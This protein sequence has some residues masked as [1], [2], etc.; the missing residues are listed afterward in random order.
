MGDRVMKIKRFKRIEDSGKFIDY[1]QWCKGS[2]SVYF[3]ELEFVIHT[4]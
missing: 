2:R 3:W 1:V 4:K